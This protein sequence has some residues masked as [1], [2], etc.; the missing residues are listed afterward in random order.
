MRKKSSDE[1][2]D[3]SSE[4][5][6]VLY[7]TA[8]FLSAT[9]AVLTS[10]VSGEVVKTALTLTVLPP[11]KFCIGCNFTR[12]PSNAPYH[13]KCFPEPEKT[14]VPLSL[15]IVEAQDIAHGECILD[16]GV[17]IEIFP[18]DLSLFGRRSAHF[19]D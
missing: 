11:D 1:F 3:G 12:W 19:V 4:L 18:Q 5:G 13:L 15:L 16:S 17:T 2:P 10:V 8:R 6:F 7:S 9:L 14:D